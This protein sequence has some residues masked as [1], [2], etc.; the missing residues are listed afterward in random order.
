MGKTS[1]DGCLRSKGSL[2]L[3][4]SIECSRPLGLDPSLGKA[5]GGLRPLREWRFLHGR[6]LVVRFLC[7]TILGGGVWWW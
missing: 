3:S 6:L 5:Y 4:L 2:R 7:W 1:C